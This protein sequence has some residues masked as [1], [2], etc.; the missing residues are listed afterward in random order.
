MT[1]DLRSFAS[2]Y[3]IYHVSSNVAVVITKPCQHFCKRF[4]RDFHQLDSRESFSRLMRRFGDREVGFK[5]KRVRTI[6][7]RFIEE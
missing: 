6:P 1:Y 2:I 4:C 5:D 7:K 3:S